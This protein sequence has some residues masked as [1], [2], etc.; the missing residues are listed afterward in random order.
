MTRIEDNV[1]HATG[2]ELPPA[3]HHVPPAQRTESSWTELFRPP[4]LRRTLVVW[5]IWIGAY[6]VYYGISTWLPSL[7][8][9]VFHLPLEV[10]LR[11]G[12]V[13][14]CVGLVGATLCAL[15]IDFV[16]RRIWFAVALGGSAVCLFLLALSGPDQPSDLMIFGSGA[17][18]FAAAAAIGVYLYTPELYPT[19]IR[20]IGV[21]TATAWLGL[22]SMVGP[23]VI[24]TFLGHGMA[25]LFTIFGMTALVVSVIVT[26]FAVETKGKVLEDRSS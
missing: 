16:G 4:Y 20:A 8:R 19:R 10:A 26:V 6:L 5:T 2:R 17:C 23:I 3:G 25:M 18:F 14:N 9:T 11:Y 22:T 24:G 12:L 7:Y 1:E 15:T 21:G 13:S